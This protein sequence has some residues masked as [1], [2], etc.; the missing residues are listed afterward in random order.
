MTSAST[1]VA[2]AY[3]I[4]SAFVGDEAIEYLPPDA[5]IRRRQKPGVLTLLDG[6]QPV[7]KCIL[8]A[9]RSASTLNSAFAWYACHS[10]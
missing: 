1:L 10:Y 5:L 8:I 4:L 7:P 9:R 6:R 3:L 2:V